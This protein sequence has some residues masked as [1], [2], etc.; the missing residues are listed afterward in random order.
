MLKS[1]T[2]FGRARRTAASGDRDITAEIKSVNSRYLDCTVKTPRGYSFLE[3]RVKSYLTSRGIVRGKIEV[4]IG[5]DVIRQTGTEV[6]LDTA[7]AQSYINALY[8]LRDTFSLPD[9]ITVMKVAENREIFT[10][11]RAE[12]DMERDWADVLPVLAE[13]V[14]LFEARA[15]TLRRTS[16]QRRRESARSHTRSRRCPRRISARTAR[17][18]RRGYAIFSART[19]RRSTKTASSRRL[20]YSPTAPAST[21]S[22]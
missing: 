21:K 16:V 13:A 9:D 3:E 11:T 1:M 8:A 10:V 15:Q 12:D 6:G 7:A 22:L 4:Y 20:R 19:T 14:D 5:I 17:S 2:A 18:S